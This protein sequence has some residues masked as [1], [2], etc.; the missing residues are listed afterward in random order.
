MSPVAHH[1]GHRA[2]TTVEGPLAPPPRQVV[3]ISKTVFAKKMEG[4]FCFAVKPS[5]RPGDAPIGA[6]S[7]LGRGLQSL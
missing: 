4:N 7:G 6:L 2:V 5:V 3:I 1:Y